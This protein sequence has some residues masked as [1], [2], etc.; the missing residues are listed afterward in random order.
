MKK[1]DP[2]QEYLDATAREARRL[3]SFTAPTMLPPPM[4]SLSEKCATLVDLFVALKLRDFPLE[5]PLPAEHLVD[6]VMAR[7][8]NLD[9]D[10][11]R[12]T[13]PCEAVAAEIMCAAPDCHCE[14]AHCSRFCHV[15]RYRLDCLIAAGFRAGVLP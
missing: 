14:A 9:D 2:M 12:D 6:R 15:H 5:S 13:I 10:S 1:V 4:Q 7:I 11:E 3:A 8:S